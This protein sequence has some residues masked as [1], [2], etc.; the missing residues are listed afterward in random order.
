MIL[1]NKK[2]IIASEWKVELPPA[3]N[4]EQQEVNYV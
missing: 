3:L 4:S 2:Q 1:E